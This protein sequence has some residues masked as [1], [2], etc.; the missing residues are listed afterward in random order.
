MLII[1]KCGLVVKVPSEG[2]VM[3]GAL[4]NMSPS[5]ASSETLTSIVW[6]ERLCYR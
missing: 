1:L 3:L 5:T 6:L 4:V 2:I